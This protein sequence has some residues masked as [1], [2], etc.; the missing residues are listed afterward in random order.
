VTAR[1]A[2]SEAHS[3]SWRQVQQSLGLLYSVTDPPGTMRAEQQGQTEANLAAIIIGGSV[4][5][6]VLRAFL[7]PTSNTIAIL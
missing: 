3:A 4:V 2:T 7:P 1:G 5:V 6:V